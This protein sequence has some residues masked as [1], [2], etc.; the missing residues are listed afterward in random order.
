MKLCDRALE[1]PDSSW[2]YHYYAV[3]IDKVLEVGVNISKYHTLEMQALKQ[4]TSV[5]AVVRPQKSDG[6]SPRFVTSAETEATDDMLPSIAPSTLASA[7]GSTSPSTLGSSTS[8]LSPS[9][10][11]PNS[12]AT[13]P[14]TASSG[15]PT[16]PAPQNII[17]D[18]LRCPGCFKTFKG[19]SGPTNLQRHLKYS[20]AHGIVQKSEC[21]IA[22]C[23]KT[24][25]RTDN[26]HHHIRTVHNESPIVPMQQRGG[27]KRRRESDG[28][29][30][31]RP[32]G[33]RPK[34]MVQENAVILQGQDYDIRETF[35][36]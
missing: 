31:I 16:S 13:S 36:F 26:M 35:V 8:E 22:G 24:F 28:T 17:A 14:T 1:Q 3:V 7:S 33:I 30:D 5:L 10:E 15:S 9:T 18:V 29:G 34:G 2:R 6:H 21:H 23:G 19:T 4:E 20:N 27:M 12:Y 25:T 11:S 32:R